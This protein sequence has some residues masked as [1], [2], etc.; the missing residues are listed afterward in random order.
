[1]LRAEFE[2]DRNPAANFADTVAEVSEIRDAAEIGEGRRGHGGF[3]GGDAADL[4]DTSDG[5]IPGQVSAGTGLGALSAFEM[6]GLNA[7]QEGLLKSEFG[8]SKFIEI[9]AVG[10]LLIG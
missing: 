4:G 9:T 7:S 2:S 8:G 10:F 1:M 3:A 6:E 5:F